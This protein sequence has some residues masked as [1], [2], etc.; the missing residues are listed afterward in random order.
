M[1]AGEKNGEAWE[2][3]TGTGWKIVPGSE[4]SARMVSRSQKTASGSRVIKIDPKTLKVQPIIRYPF[5]DMFNFSTVA[6]KVGKEI[7]VGSVRGGPGRAFP[8]GAARSS[9]S[10]VDPG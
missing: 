10:S 1:Q 9:G 4:A 3:H 6:V 8:D 5:N 2:W 7:W